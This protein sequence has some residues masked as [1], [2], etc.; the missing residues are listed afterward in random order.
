[1]FLMQLC[2]KFQFSQRINSLHLFNL[3]KIMFS[4]HYG[5]INMEGNIKFEI[6]IYPMGK[7]GC[8]RWD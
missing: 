8:K 3:L 1:M 5:Y 4:H 7:I 2:D 6:H